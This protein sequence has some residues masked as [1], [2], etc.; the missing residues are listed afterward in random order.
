MEDMT[1]TKI[2][3]CLSIHS[4]DLSKAFWEDPVIIHL[5]PGLLELVRVKDG[6]AQQEAEELLY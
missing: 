3:Q 2:V 6:E 1:E 5:A 4:L